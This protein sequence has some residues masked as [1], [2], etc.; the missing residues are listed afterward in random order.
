[1]KLFAP[2][3]WRRLSSRVCADLLPL[4][5]LLFYG[6]VRTQ[7]EQS[8]AS[9]A[10]NS[11]QCVYIK[12]AN[13]NC[14][15]L[16]VSIFK[17]VLPS[18]AAILNCRRLLQAIHPTHVAMVF[19]FLLVTAGL[20][21]G[22]T[23]WT[24]HFYLKV[25]KR[26]PWWSAKPYF[27]ALPYMGPSWV[28]IASW[29]W[30]LGVLSAWVATAMTVIA[31]LA[32]ATC[33]TVHDVGT[34]TASF[35]FDFRGEYMKKIGHY[36][37]GIKPILVNALGRALEM[38]QKIP[39]LARWWRSSQKSHFLGGGAAEN[40]ND[41][42]FPRPGIGT[43]S[44][45]RPDI[46]P[47]RMM[48]PLPV[49]M[50]TNEPVASILR[51][52]NH[53][54]VLGVEESASDDTLRKAKRKLSLMTHPDKAGN[55]PGA[56]DA[57]QRV[58]EASDTLC[59]P[60]RRRTYDEEMAIARMVASGEAASLLERTADEVFNATGVDITKM[61][62]SVLMACDS[63]PRGVHQLP[64]VPE[65]TDPGSARWCSTCRAYHAVAEEEVWVESSFAWQG[66]VP[67][68]RLRMFVCATGKIYDA[69]ELGECSG[70]LEG[71]VHSRLPPNPCKNPLASL[72]HGRGNKKGSGE[73]QGGGNRG[74]KT[75]GKSK[76]TEPVAPRA[77]GGKRRKAKVGSRKK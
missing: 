41:E 70:L 56:P 2:L 37:D 34:G 50:G 40:K 13:T 52:T 9:N 7:T 32:L 69:T 31:F 38:M 36:V 75:N 25:S 54:E 24:V 72:P 15:A 47:V 48:D 16:N 12:G 49:P 39:I 62:V 55:A 68:R 65:R 11:L 53:Y 67:G 44:Y 5:T 42:P 66:L 64:I 28:V 6:F 46:P 71:W 57:C 30:R 4:F 73:H 76:G 63:C 26:K 35:E 27:H 8:I 21:I 61:N 20:G 60:E 58:L 43:G 74:G 45:A 3:S 14:Q 19:T 18:T 1:M 77:H 51:A 17:A 10:R 22:T 23:M 33:V 59:D 29:L